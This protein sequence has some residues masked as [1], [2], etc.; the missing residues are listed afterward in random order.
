MVINCIM[1]VVLKIIYDSV[2]CPSVCVC[3][4]IRRDMR[5]DITLTQLNTDSTI[6]VLASVTIKKYYK[7]F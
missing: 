2:D 5:R 7:H 6:N 3:H 4:W 1:N